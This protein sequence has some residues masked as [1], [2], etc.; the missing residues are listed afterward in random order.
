MRQLARAEYLLR[1]IST[2]AP[3]LTVTKVL[4]LAL[5]V[6]ELHLNLS[7]PRS[8]PPFLK[9]ETT[10]DCQMACPGCQHGTR[11]KKKELMLR[12]EQLRLEDFKRMIEPI[13]RAILGISLSLRGEPLL[14][15]DV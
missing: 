6:V 12:R 5:N 13:H 8:L 11:Q 7:R 3:Y 9:V 4:N 10:P 1:H 15:K 14:G 2:F